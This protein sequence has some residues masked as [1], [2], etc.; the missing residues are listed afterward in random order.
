MTQTKSKH[1]NFDIDFLIEQIYSITDEREYTIPHRYIEEKRYLPKHLTP[2]PGFFEFTYM[3]YLTEI[4]DCLHPESGI[5]TVIVMKSAQIGYTVGILENAVLYHIGSN[6][7][8]VQ[9]V[10]AD[11]NLADETVKT[12]IDP[13]I[14]YSGIRDMIFPQSKRRGNRATGDTAFLKEYPGGFA[15]FGG[16]K[17]ADRFRGRTYQVSLFD[18]IDAWDDDA[19]EGSKI[20]LA[21]NRS[22]AF[23]ATRKIIMGSTPLILQTSNIYSYYMAGDRRNFFVPCPRCG[24]FQVLRWHGVKESGKQFGIK[25]EV[26]HGKPVYESIHYQCEHCG[27]K[28]YDHEKTILLPNGEWKP[29]FESSKRRYRSY[30]INAL[31]SPPGIYGWDKIVEEWS[32]CWD[33]DKNRLK[34]KEKAR[35]FWNTKRGLPWE[36]RGES[37]NYEKANMK[38]VFGWRRGTIE[39]KFPIRDTGGRILLL[40]CAVDVQKNNLFVDIKGWTAGGRSYTLDF[41]DIPGPTEDDNSISW[42]ELDKLLTHGQWTDEEGNIF[43][44]SNTFIDSGRYTEN[45]YNFCSQFSNGVYPIKGE[46]YL[47]GGVIMKMF[48]KEIIEKAR[49]R[50]GIGYRLNVT[51]LKDRTAHCMNISDWNSGALQPDWYPNFP[52]DL[53]D[54]YFRQFEAE[55]KVD[56]YEKVTNKY[57]RSRWKETSPGRPNHAFDTFGYSIGALYDIAESTCKI[58]LGLDLLDWEEFWKYA[59]SGIFY[60]KPEK[61]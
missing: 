12:R 47:P 57:R 51:A 34:D 52:E 31:Y 24:E 13:M 23:S 28:F 56:E 6:P 46:D 25:F 20:D 14:D 50:S 9:F 58:E 2:K 1:T 22:N 40:T 30:W 16:A 10:T 36:E 41:Y 5:E 48:S 45:V 59:E 15:S 11:K 37:V 42:A 55:I 26:E 44:I 35:V 54:D 38:R 4:F 18:E 39:Q 49:L 32:D 21:L 7:R 53:G 8:T 19:K 43:R 61:R 33:L 29:T 17:N 3:P 60:Q 27:G